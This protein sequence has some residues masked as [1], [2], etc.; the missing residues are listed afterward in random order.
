MVGYNC[1]AAHIK[2][3]S[4]RDSSSFEHRIRVRATQIRLACHLGHECQRFII[5]RT[6]SAR[7]A[8]KIKVVGGE[9]SLDTGNGQ[10]NHYNNTVISKKRQT[11][12]KVIPVH[13]TKAYRGNRGTAPLIL[14]FCSSWWSAVNFTPTPFCIAERNLAIYLL[15]RWVGTRVGLDVSAEEIEPRTVQPKTYSLY[16]LHY[17]AT[18]SNID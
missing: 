15:E 16:L 4:S 7:P 11:I 14:N 6:D 10:S 9:E 5:P 13:P 12:S 3:W 1:Y 2:D 17:P 8:G 18:C